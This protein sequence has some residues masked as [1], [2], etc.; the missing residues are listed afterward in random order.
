MIFAIDQHAGEKAVYSETTARWWSYPEI[1]E[2]VARER[3]ALDSIPKALLFNFCRND[4]NSLFPYLAALDAGH[5]VAMLDDVLSADFKA[6]LIELY[7]PDFI[8]S[9]TSI[10]IAGYEPVRGVLWRRS[11]PSEVPLH[12]DLSLLLSTSG[13]TGSPKFVRLTR[14]NVES[15]AASICEVLG[16]GPADRAIASLPMHYS[17]GLSVL[18]THLLA[19][20]GVVLTDEGLLTA[21]FWTA[22]RTLECTSLAGVPYSYQ[23]LNRLNPDRL[24]VP[25]LQTMTQA[26]GKLNNELIARFSEWMA[27]R[28]GRFFVMYGQTEAA[29]RI[30]TLPHDALPAKLGPVGPP[31]P[32]GRVEIEIDSGL[33]TEP[34]RT[35]EL[36]YSGPNVMMGYATSRADLALGDIL[37]GRLH[38]GDMAYL[39]E[40]GYIYMTGR[41]KRDAKLFGL[42]INLDEVENMLRVYGPTAVVSADD[43]LCIYC[44]Y[45]DEAAFAQYRQELA[46]RLKV[47]YNAFA[48]ERVAKLPTTSSGKIDYRGLGARP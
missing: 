33:T 45:G 44:E 47:N 3:E 1:S 21:G 14:R 6:K 5:A 42:R 23:I 32:G 46:D 36:V 29:P 2:A 30:S 18:N 9:R 25:S 38:T 22:F 17:Y 10:P 20:A 12:P 19:G 39:D 27:R 11:R 24:N 15:N 4:E 16:I 34:K 41:A 31:I 13:S 40:Q 48:F 35:G 28:G 8:V 26:G 7:Q 37:G 43:K